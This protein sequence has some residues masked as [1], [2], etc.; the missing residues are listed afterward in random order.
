MKYLTILLVSVIITLL[1]VIHCNVLQ[2][3]QMCN[4]DYL[5]EHIDR[6]QQCHNDLSC[7]DGNYCLCCKQIILMRTTSSQEETLCCEVFI[8]IHYYREMCGTELDIIETDDKMKHIDTLHSVTGSAES[9]NSCSSNRHGDS[10]W[11]WRVAFLVIGLISA[12]IGMECT[13]Q[14]MT[15]REKIKKICCC[16]ASTLV[17]LCILYM[18][19]SSK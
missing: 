19:L 18:Y 16:T 15:R 5:K 13:Y 7:Q 3:P 10:W 14:I 1:P 12:Y 2:V 9:I 17:C 4:M 6:F 8:K 11:D